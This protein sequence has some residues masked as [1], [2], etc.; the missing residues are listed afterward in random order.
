MTQKK[1]LKKRR[2][3]SK[4]T[5]ERILF[6]AMKV[7]AEHG[8]SNATTRLI[9]AESQANVALVNYYFRSKAG[10]YKAVIA[11]LFEG[12]GKTLMALPDMVCD[13]TSWQAAMKTWIKRALEICAAS[14]PPELWAA[15]LMGMEECVPSEL[16]QDI[17]AKFA[18]PVR[19]S[20]TR[21][22]RMGMKQDNPLELNLWAST[23]NAQCVIYALTRKRWLTR[24]CPPEVEIKAWLDQ[25][26]NHICDGIFARLSFQR[27]IN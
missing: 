2:L 8:F 23:V 25:V 19:D 3:D 26:A 14:K 7:F 12:T 1:P 10:L 24:Y 9:C 20:F 11:A 18:R 22:L 17:E 16:A 21:L 27:K 4:D 5:R 6:A 15:R 13:E